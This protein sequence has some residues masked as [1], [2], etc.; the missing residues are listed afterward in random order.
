MKQIICITLLACLCLSLNAQ[1]SL[2]LS[3]DKTTSLIFPFAIKHVDRGAP[4]VLAQQVKDIPNL[5]LVKA[6]ARN[7]SETNL[8]VATED[9]SLYSFAICYDPN[10]ST[11]SL[12]L[13]V[14]TKASIESY[15]KGILDNPKA[16][17][18]LK[19]EKW[20]ISLVVNGIYIKDD[21]LYCQ[22]VIRNESPI[23]YDVKF[24]RFFIADKK[25]NKRTAIQETEL[26][27]VYSVGNNKVIKAN[28]QTVA[29]I[30][31][32]KFTLPDGRYFGIQLKEKDGGRHILV[33][34]GNHKLM[35]ASPL[36]DVK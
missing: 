24:L 30:A 29:V 6:G 26:Q 12:Q 14:Q 1:N 2:C 20:D 21:V 17:G 3:T 22:L 18:G 7:F 9:G 8:S 35:Q 28:N 5:L 15:A 27:P 31:L 23:N 16:I 11:T 4:S 36:P 33:K 13:P 19:K 25:Q 10:P 32:Q 34:I